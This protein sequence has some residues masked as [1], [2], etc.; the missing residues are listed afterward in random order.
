[1]GADG[2]ATRSFDTTGRPALR[3]LGAT[4]A[5]WPRRLALFLVVCTSTFAS[6]PQPA[7][8]A[9]PTLP[10]YGPDKH[11]GVS[12]CDGSTCHGSAGPRNDRNVLQNEYVTWVEED[13]V[14]QPMP[15]LVQLISA[16]RE[17][18]R[19]GAPAD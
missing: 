18:H 4:G 9:D 10:Q 3:A 7:R 1:M 16:S 13:V 14:M 19:A 5:A 8:A 17:A 6:L 15:K 12:S 2:M 11:E